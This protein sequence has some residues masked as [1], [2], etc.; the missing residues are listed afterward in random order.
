MLHGCEDAAHR[1]LLMM[2][3]FLNLLVS[4]NDARGHLME[5]IAG[6]ISRDD[7]DEDRLAFMAKVAA[8]QA[9]TKTKKPKE[10]KVDPIT[11]AAF[12]SLDPDDKQEFRMIGE[13]LVTMH[14]KRKLA[15]WKAE[16]HDRKKT[17]RGAHAATRSRDEAG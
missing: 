4:G 3:E 17:K 13:A 11:E 8:C 1:D 12:E 6:H 16:E 10:K 2:A 5:T 7:P 14:K 9:K 15:T